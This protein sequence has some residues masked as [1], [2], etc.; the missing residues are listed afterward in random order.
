LND[1]LNCDRDQP[2]LE[3]DSIEGIKLTE[4]EL[5][6]DF[7]DSNLNIG[8]SN[9]NSPCSSCRPGLLGL[10]NPRSFIS[11]RIGRHVACDI[12]NQTRPNWRHLIQ[13]IK[14]HGPREQIQL[15]RVG[16][17]FR[18]QSNSTSQ[19]TTIT[20]HHTSQGN[21]HRTSDFGWFRFILQPS[22]FSSSAPNL[23]H[24]EGFHWRRRR[25]D[26]EMNKQVKGE[27]KGRNRRSGSVEGVG[28]EGEK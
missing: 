8:E 6:I 13:K 21:N 11:F 20:S 12:N 19:Q 14:R 27:E 16:S 5:E 3:L 24:T 1:Q 9:N 2:Q 15:R 23:I 4:L 26:S 10:N 22:R 17:F 25:A 18:M 7:T 28:C